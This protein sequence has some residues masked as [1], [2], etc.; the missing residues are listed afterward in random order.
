M[1]LRETI[2]AAKAEGLS[3][4]EYVSKHSTPV[5]VDIP[6]DAGPVKRPAPAER[7]SEKQ[8][9]ANLSEVQMHP[10]QVSRVCVRCGKVFRV[11]SEKSRRKYCCQ[12]CRERAQYERSKKRKVEINRTQVK[13]AN[14]VVAYIDQTIQCLE[15]LK[16][17]LMNE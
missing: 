10:D 12:F 7:S 16:E 2:A 3:Y 5:T 1:T 9:E 11:I 14:L 13:N 4:G 15:R 6:N 8:P 17:A